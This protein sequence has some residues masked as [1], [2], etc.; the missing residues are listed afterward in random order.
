[1]HGKLCFGRG[2][3]GWTQNR[4]ET[5]HGHSHRKD[6][7][8]DHRKDHRK[9]H[10]RTTGRARFQNGAIHVDGKV[11]FRRGKRGCT[12]NQDQTCQSHSPGRTTCREDYRE[13]PFPKQIV[14]RKREAMFQKWA[15]RRA[16]GSGRTP[17]H[18]RP[19]RR[20]NRSRSRRSQ[21]HEKKK[22]TNYT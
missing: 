17:I 21:H 3:R 15:S 12:H 18:I 9:D 11:C 16:D 4:A 5:C 10:R 6:H 19:C 7:G 14:S 13:Y 20:T 8:G 1:M 22:K 2:K